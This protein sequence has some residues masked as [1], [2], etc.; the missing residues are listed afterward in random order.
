M[1]RGKII[2]VEG[3]SNAG[4]TTTCQ[5]MKK[6]ENCVVI[7]ECNVYEP[8]H[9]RPSQSLDH[10][11]ANQLFFFQVEMR[12]MR[13]ATKLA[14]E[15]KNVILDRCGLSIVAIAYAFERLGKYPTFQHALDQYFKLFEDG[16]LL[17]PDEYV[18]LYTDDDNTRQRNS[19]RGKKLSEEWIGS[20]FTEFQNKFYEAAANVIPHSQRISTS[21]EE[22]NYVSRIIAQIL[23]VQELTDRDL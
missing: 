12:R 9:P 14:L 11:I 21:G 18:F 23:N 17:M 10:E 4:K 1:E 8:N 3:P 5:Y 20:S 19:T 7:D 16:E 22:K 15:G 13:K 6:Y 2:V